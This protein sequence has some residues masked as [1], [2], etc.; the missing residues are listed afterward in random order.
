MEVGILGANGSINLP[1]MMLVLAAVVVGKIFRLAQIADINM[2]GQKI[3]SFHCL[4]VA[5]MTSATSSLLVISTIHPSAVVVEKRANEAPDSANRGCS[6][7][8][9]LLL[10]RNGLMIRLG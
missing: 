9:E 6:R 7:V 1:S 3:T 5:Q 10:L 2:S 8:L 4:L